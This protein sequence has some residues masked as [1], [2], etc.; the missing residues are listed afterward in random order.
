MDD[1]VNGLDRA[2]PMAGVQRMTGAD[3]RQTLAQ[4][5]SSPMLAEGKVCVI[6]LDAI[7][8]GMAARWPAR[9]EVVYEHIERTLQRQLGGHGFYLRISDTDFLVAQPNLSRLAGQAYCLNCLREVLH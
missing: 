7:R 5:Q 3:P 9:R 4:I 6:A 2:A 8:E 1:L